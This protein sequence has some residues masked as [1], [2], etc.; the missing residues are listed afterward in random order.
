MMD[1]GVSSAAVKYVAEYIGS[2]NK[3]ELNKVVSASF[4]FFVGVGVF[5]SASLFILSFFAPSI[6][7]LEPSSYLI[8]QHVL[9]I[10]AAAALLNWPLNIFNQT[11]TSA[12]RYDMFAAVNL[13]SLAIKVILV[14]WFLSHGYGVIS[15]MLITQGLNIL[16]GVV[17]FICSRIAIPGLK[18]TFPYFGSATFKKMF[19]FGSY[20]FFRGI[21]GLIGKK[22]DPLVI[23]FF[24]P[25]SYV[26]IYAVARKIE[27]LLSRVPP[28]F[29]KPVV[30]LCAELEGR[31]AFDQQRI[32]L[33]KGTRHILMIY[34]PMIIITMLYA[35]P[36]VLGWVG[37]EFQES[38]AV[39]WIFG[40]Y[41]IFT[42]IIGL[43]ASLLTSKGVVKEP[44]WVVTANSFAN[45]ILSIILVRFYGIY[46]VALGTALPVIFMK[47]PGLL[48]L[49]CKHFNISLREYFG[50]TLLPNLGVIL[51][52]IGLGSLTLRYFY[53]HSVYLTLAQMALLYASVLIFGFFMARR[54]D[55]IELLRMIGLYQ[56]KM[57]DYMPALRE[58]GE[59][60]VI[61][62]KEPLP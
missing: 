58:F 35:R 50:M 36:F 13:A 6:F 46:G 34:L 52:S 8:M 62:A 31:Q 11:L 28:I 32:L 60:E 61:M 33:E 26:T 29:I 20:V 9:W 21:S 10:G 12:Q 40:S 59:R 43:S 54:S 18:V 14:V 1:F 48:W 42:S 53:P 25:I 27:T 51:L 47:V 22:I 37:P 4:S 16:G 5:I 19:G 15:L 39:V 44:F 23:S 49:T 24:L 45:F 41:F 56:S 17:F 57:L 3:D 7:H 55:K 38:I 30:P 2:G